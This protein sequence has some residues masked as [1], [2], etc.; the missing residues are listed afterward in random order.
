MRRNLAARIAG[1]DD[2]VKLADIEYYFILSQLLIPE[3]QANCAK[4]S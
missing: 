1:T 2:S 4:P 3:L